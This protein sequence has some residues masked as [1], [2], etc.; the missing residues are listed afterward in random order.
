MT[1]DNA[2]DGIFKEGAA[3]GDSPLTR[4]RV[5]SLIEAV[6]ASRTCTDCDALLDPRIAARCPTH[7][8]TILA[9]DAARSQVKKHG[10]ELAG[11]ALMKVQGWIADLLKDEAEPK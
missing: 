6:F 9:K 2:I 3:T 8:A 7:A 4:E 11:K 1:L 5:K 10:P